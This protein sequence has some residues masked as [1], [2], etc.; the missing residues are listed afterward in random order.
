MHANYAGVSFSWHC[1]NNPDVSCKK[2]GFYVV[3]DIPDGEIRH[4]IKSIHLEKNEFILRM[5]NKESKLE[6]TTSYRFDGKKEYL[7]GRIFT[8]I[9]KDGSWV[10]K[11]IELWIS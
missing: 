6:V 7:N 8:Y 4:V 10:H 9:R 3:G 2:Y 11:N 1:E 5:E